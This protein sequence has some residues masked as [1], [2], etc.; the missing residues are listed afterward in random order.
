M[1]IVIN[2]QC[3]VTVM[4]YQLL[5]SVLF[6]I[7]EKYLFC[8]ISLFGN[9]FIAVRTFP[10][11]FGCPFQLSPQIECH[12]Q[13][14]TPCTNNCLCGR[15]FLEF[16]LSNSHLAYCLLSLQTCKGFLICDGAHAFS[17]PHLQTSGKFIFM[18]KKI[19]HHFLNLNF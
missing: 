3:P 13:S 17:V 5:S 14:S 12:R 7:S 11:L 6:L 2:Y 19:P 9:G 1:I 18:R 16:C 4:V 15:V 8:F 10:Y